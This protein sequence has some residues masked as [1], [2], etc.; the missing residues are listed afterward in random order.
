MFDVID[1]LDRVGSDASLR[2][3]SRDELAVALATAQADPVLSKAILGKDGQPLD[4]LL[5]QD[6]FCCYINPGKEDEDEEDEEDEE[7]GVEEDPSQGDKKVASSR[8]L[9]ALT[10]ST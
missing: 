2:N 9:H 1:F 5:G 8:L 6:A 10:S 3:A 7:D 4:A